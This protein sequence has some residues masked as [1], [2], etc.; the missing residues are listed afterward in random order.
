[1]QN[2]AAAES[3]FIRKVNLPDLYV[4]RSTLGSKLKLAMEKCDGSGV[5]E[6][7][8]ARKLRSKLGSILVETLQSYCESPLPDSI[9]TLR[10]SATAGMNID[11][12]LTQFSII[13]DSHHFQVGAD[14]S[15][16]TSRSRTAAEK[17]AEKRGISLRV[18]RFNQSKDIE[19][20]EAA[21]TAPGGLD[22]WCN[23][24]G[25]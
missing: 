19:P 25:R 14:N 24:Y 21:R 6:E 23:S 10:R 18:M 8:L 7:I 5:D 15:Y 17:L 3:S 11:G 13:H 9:V 20:Y 4:Q 16:T 2:E 12:K 22:I 1:M